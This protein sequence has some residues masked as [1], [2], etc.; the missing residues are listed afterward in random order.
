MFSREL[1][2]G[3]PDA[4]S[5]VGQRSAQARQRRGLRRHLHL[6]RGH[7]RLQGGELPLRLSGQPGADRL[8]QRWQFRRAP[9]PPHQLEPRHPLNGYVRHTLSESPVSGL[10]AL[11]WP[12]QIAILPLLG[13]LLD[14][15]I[16]SHSG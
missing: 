1:T 4:R 16:V 14:D 5:H 15:L 7:D 9:T 8:R 2:R 12:P 11:G 10:P 3:R 6:L 13:D